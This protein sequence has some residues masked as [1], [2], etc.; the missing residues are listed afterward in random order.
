M[1]ILMGKEDTIKFDFDSMK[2]IYDK[3]NTLSGE[4]TDILS[5]LKDTSENAEEKMKGSYREGYEEKRKDVID[6][7][8]KT[9][10][11]LGKLCEYLEEASK[12]F[13]NIELISY[14]I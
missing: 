5:D 3:I 14:L 7:F 1:G 10:N 6:E 4:I 9:N 11:N 12:E 2:I 8:Y 13:N